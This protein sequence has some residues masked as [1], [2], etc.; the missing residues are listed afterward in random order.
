LKQG[1][2]GSSSYIP[3]GLSKSEYEAIRK[4]DA[5][6]ASSNYQKNVA[7]AGKFLPYD[8]FYLQR[9]TDLSGGWKKTVTLGHRM[10]KT[11][12]DWSGEK[13][14]TKKFEAVKAPSIF[15]KK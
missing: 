12:F 10:A 14:E 8:D 9:G 2:L 11:A 3:A 7:K 6:K 1:S 5:A 13:D 15:G 4:K